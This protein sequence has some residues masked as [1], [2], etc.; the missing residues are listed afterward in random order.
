LGLIKNGLFILLLVGLLSARILAGAAPRATYERY[1]Q[2]V[3]SRDIAGFARTL[4]AGEVFHYIDS[5]GRRT[6]SRQEYLEAHRR[7]FGEANWTIEYEPPLVVERDEAAY[8]MAIFHYR[9]TSKDGRIARLDGYFTLIMFKEHG[10]WRMVADIV[11]R[12]TS[13][14]DL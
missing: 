11:T 9:E 13:R 14:Q 10:E 7:W 3:M 6:D 5:R 1:V 2:S 4:T 8:A 12:I